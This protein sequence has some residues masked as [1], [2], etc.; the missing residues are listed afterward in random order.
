MLYPNSRILIFAKAPLPGKVKTRLIPAYGERFATELHQAMVWHLLNFL[1][2]ANI[3]PIELWCSP[4]KNHLFFEDCEKSFDI[5]LHTQQ[6]KHLGD[7]L[8]NAFKVVLAYAN[9]AVVLGA[10]CPTIGREDFTTAFKD[11]HAGVDVVIK[12]ADDGGYLLLG[13]SRP[14]PQLFENITWGSADVFAQTVLCA[15]TL[16]LKYTKLAVGRDID[17]A[18][19]VQYLASRAAYFNL[20]SRLR[21]L[22]NSVRNG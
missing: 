5:S 21:S 10:D 14:I 4:D 6:G 7:K 22:L 2:S 16:K 20:H 1:C 9:S 19:D 11:V 13:L 18:S 12:P 3:S 8:N 15:D 17:N